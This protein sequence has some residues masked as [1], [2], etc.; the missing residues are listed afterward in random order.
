M[1][2]EQIGITWSIFE[3][4]QNNIKIGQHFE[5]IAMKVSK[6]VRCTH[7]TYGM[8]LVLKFHRLAI[9][10]IKFDSEIL[11][12]MLTQIFYSICLTLLVENMPLNWISTLV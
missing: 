4:E 6:C 9:R 3:L 5:R 12:P 10:D 2:F 1:S 11:L 7:H 8:T